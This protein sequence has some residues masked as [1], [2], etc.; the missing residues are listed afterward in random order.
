MHV[1]PTQHACFSYTHL[2][3]NVENSEV[4]KVH[5]VRICMES[6]ILI[7]I[8]VSEYLDSIDLS[9]IGNMDYVQKISFPMCWDV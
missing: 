5:Q 2:C 1:F 4:E 3:W 7:M 6:S 9:I 8:S